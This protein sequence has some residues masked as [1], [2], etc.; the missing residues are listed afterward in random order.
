MLDV[1]EM[2]EVLGLQLEDPGRGR[3]SNRLKRDM[4][5]QAQYKLANLLHPNY[6]TELEY[7]DL[8]KTA[9]GGVLNFSGLTYHVLKGNQGILKVKLHDGR[10]CTRINLKGLRDTGNSM[11]AGSDKNPLYYVYG[12]IIY[13]LCSTTN[14]VIDVFYLRNPDPLNYPVVLIGI[15]S[16]TGFRTSYF[17]D[18]SIYGNDY[19]NGGLIFCVDKNSY[20]VVTDYDKSNQE[21]LVSPAAGAN[22]ATNETIYLLRHITKEIE[23]LGLD[24]V[25]PNLNGSLHQLMVDMAEAMCWKSGKKKAFVDRSKVALDNVLRQIKGLNE[26]MMGGPNNGR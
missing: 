5:E 12:K 18:D 11:L 25:Y 7:V 22:F 24:S 4:L 14:P 2:L 16:T 6:L 3:F 17:S 19:F 1:Y 26:K 10:Y 9:T 15:T 8:S 23:I 20:H 13:V 21:F